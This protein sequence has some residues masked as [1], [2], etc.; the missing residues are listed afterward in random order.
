[1]WGIWVGEINPNRPDVLSAAT[2]NGWCSSPWR[3]LAMVSMYCSMAGGGKA[4]GNVTGHRWRYV[5][6]L[7][8]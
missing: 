6:V 7:Y 4:V 1:M 2:T 5:I 8:H 3:A